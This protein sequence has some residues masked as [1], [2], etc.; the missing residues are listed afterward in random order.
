MTKCFLFSNKLSEINGKLVLHEEEN[1]ILNYIGG[2]VFQRLKEDSQEEEFLTSNFLVQI[3][4]QDTEELPNHFD[5]TL[6]NF[7][8]LLLNSVR[9][10]NQ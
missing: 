7:K 10:I 5:E 6:N 3:V 9:I 1:K 8:R 4:R 2:K